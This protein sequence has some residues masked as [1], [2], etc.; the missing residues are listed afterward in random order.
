M[1]RRS[2]LRAQARAIYREMAAQAPSVPPQENSTA[3]NLTEK[4]RA[5]YEDSAV[6][7]REIARLA[8]VTERTI[9]K[10]AR[11]QHWKPRYARAEFAPVKG[12][13]ARFIRRADKGKPIATGLKATDPAGA[14]RAVESCGAAQLLSREAQREAEAEQRSEAL[15]RALEL[16]NTA[17]GNLREF[18]EARGKGPPGPLDI[19]AE[20]I[21]MRVVEMALAQ[22]Q[23]LVAEEEAH[24]KSAIA[25]LRI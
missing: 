21:L 19:R 4:A 7:V 23:A 20:D 10:Y 11:K 12:A 3:L 18:H 8:G 25:D 1:T 6:P 13:G 14:A 24:R 16:N 5:L 2:S 15:N 9:Y 22:V 17:L